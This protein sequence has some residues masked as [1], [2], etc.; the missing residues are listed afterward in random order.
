MKTL[1]SVMDELQKRD[2]TLICV[3]KNNSNNGY[4]RV[5]FNQRAHSHFIN[6]NNVNIKLENQLIKRQRT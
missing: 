4:F 1:S 3:N 2:G 5:P 6:K